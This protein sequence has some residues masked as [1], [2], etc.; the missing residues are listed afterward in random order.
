MKTKHKKYLMLGL[1]ALSLL[2]IMNLGSGIIEFLPD[3]LVLVGNLDEAAAG[4]LVYEALKTLLG[5]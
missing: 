2:Y 1:G 5:R 4:A 3:N